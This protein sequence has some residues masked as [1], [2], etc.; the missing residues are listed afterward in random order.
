MMMDDA[1]KIKA[2]A[3]LRTVAKRLASGPRRELI[4]VTADM[5]ETGGLDTIESAALLA[6]VSNPRRLSLDDPVVREFHIWTLGFESGLAAQLG[7]RIN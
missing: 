2:V 1:E 7:P 3:A 6:W 4:T 5:L